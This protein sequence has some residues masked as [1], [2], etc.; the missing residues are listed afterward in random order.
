MVPRKKRGKGGKESSIK[1]SIVR[2]KSDTAFHTHTQIRRIGLDY[3]LNGVVK[4]KGGMEGGR[5]REGY[6]GQLR[7]REEGGRE[8]GHEAV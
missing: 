6:Q 8:G 1:A 5:G 3:V 7:M 4:A 2:V